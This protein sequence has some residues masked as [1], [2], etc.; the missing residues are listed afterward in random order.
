VA[1][2]IFSEKA[3]SGGDTDNKKKTITTRTG[4]TITFDDSDGS[5]LI[6]DHKDKDVYEPL[7]K[8]SIK[9]DGKQNIHINADTSILLTSGKASIKLESDG[10]GT[11]TVRAKTIQFYAGETY[12]LD[13][14]K[15]IRLTSNETFD[16]DAIKSSTVNSSGKTTVSSI[17]KTIITSMGEVAVDGTIIKLN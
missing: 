2:S 15:V 8:S 1:G 5:I 6:Q 10:D 7:S 14:G 16:A 9:M 11:I 12:T 3:S 17:A 4:S 13:S